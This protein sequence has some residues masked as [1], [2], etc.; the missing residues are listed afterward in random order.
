[1]FCVFTV[2]SSTNSLW[3]RP[4]GGDNNTI[5]VVSVSY[6]SF[7]FVLVTDS[8]VSVFPP[9]SPP[10]ILSSGI[11]PCGV[12]PVDAFHAPSQTWASPTVANSSLLPASL[13]NCNISAKFSNVKSSLSSAVDS[14]EIVLVAVIF[15][16]A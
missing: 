6:L 10:S 5:S 8:F 3:L 13:E 4:V 9:S 15:I 16:F 7:V 14:G 2:P 12:Y 1:M 11:P